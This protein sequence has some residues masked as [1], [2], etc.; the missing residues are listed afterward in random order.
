MKPDRHVA[1]VRA[2]SSTRFLRG[3]AVLGIATALFAAHDG[4][5]GAEAITSPTWI[6]SSATARAVAVRGSRVQVVPPGCVTREVFVV[7]DSL[8]VGAAAFGGLL[9]RATEVGFVALVDARVARFTVVGAQTLGSRAATG[10]LEPLVMVA[11]GTNDV[12]NAVNGP[13][14]DAL[15]DQTMRAIGPARTVV[16]VNL[17][18]R[19]GWRSDAF[20]AALA[21][22]AARYGNLIIAN[23]HAHPSSTA[24]ASDGVHLTIAGYRA[25]AEFMI[26]ALV[27]LPCLQQ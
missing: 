14:L 22:A 12:F 9:T 24:F 19:A 5:S 3:V 7:G 21:R 8:T 1:T 16:W 13:R 17:R 18:L 15:I 4:R 26:D 20:N 6:A 25:R 2:D 27:R 10:Q 23:W 11:L